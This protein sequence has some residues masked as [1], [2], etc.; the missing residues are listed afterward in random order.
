MPLLISDI[1]SLTSMLLLYVYDVHVKRSRFFQ[2]E[3]P[4]NIA[5]S[6]KLCTASQRK[7]AE[8]VKKLLKSGQQEPKITRTTLS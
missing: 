1:V 3:Q 6:R 4:G 2:L 8:M 7:V 5:A